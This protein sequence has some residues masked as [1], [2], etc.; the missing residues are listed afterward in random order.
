MADSPPSSSVAATGLPSSLVAAAAA[1]AAAAGSSSS[2]SSAAA[3]SP[4]SPAAAA[5]SVDS[6]TYF[7]VDVAQIDGAVEL[8]YIAYCNLFNQQIFNVED[9]VHYELCI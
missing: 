9:N 1:A 6:C 4:S 3:G 5:D 8:A 2:S 7:D